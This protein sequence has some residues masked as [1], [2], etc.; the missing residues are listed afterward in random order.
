MKFGLNFFVISLIFIVLAVFFEILAAKSNDEKM[1]AAELWCF[2]HGYPYVKETQ[3]QY[4]CFT[5]VDVTPVP[6]EI[7]P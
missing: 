3:D 7:I 6:G 2:Q 5:P 1:E 4:F